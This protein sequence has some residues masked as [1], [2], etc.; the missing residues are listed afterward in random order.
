[1]NIRK[2][3]SAVDKGKVAVEAIKGKKTTAELS[4]EY[5]VTASQISK[6][7]KQLLDSIPQIFSGKRDKKI[8]NQEALIEE[9]YN[10]IGHLT[11]KVKWLKK[12]SES[13]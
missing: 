5:A 3:R 10:E 1:M 6:W 2:N 12:K 11:Y 4:S 9:L 8:Q 13:V 7:K